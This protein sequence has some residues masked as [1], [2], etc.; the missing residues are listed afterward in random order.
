[1]VA[2]VGGSALGLS[3][4]TLSVLGTRATWGGAALGRCTDQAYVNGY[5]GNLV[6]RGQ[7]EVLVGR[8]GMVGAVDAVFAQASRIITRLLERA[9]QGTNPLLAAAVGGTGRTRRPAR[10]RPAT[11]G[12]SAQVRGRR[13]S[14][15]VAEDAPIGRETPPSRHA[16]EAAGSAPPAK[17][18]APSAGETALRIPFGNKEAALR[19]G[20]RYRAGGWYAPPGVGLDA[21]RERG[22]L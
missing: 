20:A 17:R 1:M 3:L 15:A 6:L 11:A 10:A 7:D 9:G 19:L 12:R 21:F 18:T 16:S 22:W 14:A 4:G 13:G 2:I 8:Q 5:S